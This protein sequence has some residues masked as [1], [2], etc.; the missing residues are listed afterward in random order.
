MQA[1]RTL[2]G[3][4]A[5]VTVEQLVN[6]FVQRQRDAMKSYEAWRVRQQLRTNSAAHV[7][8]LRQHAAEV[9]DFYNS[10]V[11]LYL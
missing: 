9:F 2:D 1:D 8:Q 5:V 3:G 7:N 10:L 11:T 6:Q 4:D